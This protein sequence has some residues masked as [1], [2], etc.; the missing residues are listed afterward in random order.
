MFCHFSIGQGKKAPRIAWESVG[1]Y[2]SVARDFIAPD[3]IAQRERERER[4]RESGRGNE[5]ELEL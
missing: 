2:A 4:E 1:R 5:V 3:E